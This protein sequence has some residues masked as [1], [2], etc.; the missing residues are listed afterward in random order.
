[1]QKS[2]LNAQA[3]LMIE[4]LIDQIV[5]YDDKMKIYYKTPITISPDAD[6]GFSFYTTTKTLSNKRNQYL[7]NKTTMIIEMWIA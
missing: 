2:Y 5:L 6:Q 4:L 1:M 3:K 7:H